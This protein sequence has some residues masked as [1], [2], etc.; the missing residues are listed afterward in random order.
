MP[1]RDVL[2]NI[3]DP[4]LIPIGQPAAAP[5]V[6]EESKGLFTTFAENR[7]IVLIVIIVIIAIGVFAYFV[8]Y[9]GT[10][11]EEIGGSQQSQQKA[12]GFHNFSGQNMNRGDVSQQYLQQQLQQQQMQQHQQFLQN[13]AQ[14]PTQ[15]PQNLQQQQNMMPPQQNM[16]QQPPQQQNMM[17][18]QQ[19]MMPPQQP[20]FQPE[21]KQPVKSNNSNGSVSAI[22]LLNRSKNSMMNMHD[23]VKNLAMQN[24]VTAP[25]IATQRARDEIAEPEGGKNVSFMENQND[26]N[27]HETDEQNSD[28]DSMGNNDEKLMNNMLGFN[29]RRNE[30]G[31]ERVYGHVD[32][33]VHETTENDESD[34]DKRFNKAFDLQQEN[35]AGIPPAAKAPSQIAHCEY[36]VQGRYCK[37]PVQYG[38]KCHKHYDK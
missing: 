3:T 9:K 14:Q 10:D 1:E 34:L 28:N 22:D 18:P 12:S 5:P 7:V 11:K 20:A 29:E 26:N 35:L 30:N 36:I 31:N 17:P 32:D 23:N 33:R 27:M 25:N 8:A 6:V 4:T 19:N 38:N 21:T 15:Q 2:P 37:L 24:V 16:T 13:M